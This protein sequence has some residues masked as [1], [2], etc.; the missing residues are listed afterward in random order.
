MSQEMEMLKKRNFEVELYSVH[1]DSIN[2]YNFIEKTKAAFD[3]IWS[4]SEYKRVKKYLGKSKPDVVHVHNF[5]PII[6]PSVYYACKK[7]N[8]PVVQ[9][10]HNYRLLCPAATFMREGKVCEKCSEKSLLYSLYYG[11]YKD[12]RTNT[13]PLT[14]MISINR[15]I[16]TWDNKVDKY[17][18]LTNFAKQKFVE[19][20][21]PEQKIEVKPNFIKRTHDINE[22]LDKDKVIL[23]VGRI[24]K[25]KGI[26]N[27]LDSWEKVN[28]K[29]GYS[30]IVLG[31]G[32]ERENCLKQYK[33]KSIKFLGKKSHSDVLNYIR[34]AKYIVVPSIWYEGFPMTI[35]EAY[36][37]GTPIIASEIGSLKEVVTNGHT[38]FLF[39]YNS[40]E[41]MVNTL[42]KAITINDEEYRYIA[43]C[44][45][46]GFNEKYTEEL[47]FL[48][49]KSIYLDVRRERKSEKAN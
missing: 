9:T 42:E 46:D 3:A 12:S 15:A 19:G 29:N 7:M 13:I 23:F 32:P 40:I 6:S 5:F 27:L 28:N 16:K 33:S 24:T 14:S 11:C 43:K 8:I 18:A 25:E 21:L 35:I 39:K 10:L 31:D 38:G 30:L 45:H 48:H 20:G 26:Y 22:I 34:K 36:S 44:V 17:I 49:L 1:N 4:F 37:V 41:D 2:N 47:N